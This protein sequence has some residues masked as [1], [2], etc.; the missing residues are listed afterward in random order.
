MKTIVR[1][2][3]FLAALVGVAATGLG[4]GSV[5]FFTSSSNSWVGQGESFTA[6][7][8]NGFTITAQRLPNNTV[9][10]SIVSPA[11]SWFLDFAAPDGALLA[12][13]QYF[14]AEQ[15]P[16]QPAGV[17]GMNFYSN[18]RSSSSIVGYFDVIAVEYGPG[19]TIN[20][21]DADFLQYDEGQSAR[22]NQGS[23]RFDGFAPVPE[24]GTAPLILAGVLTLLAM[25][26]RRCPR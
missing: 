9:S 6:S 13:N 1:I 24:P 2:S 7:S 21:F 20:R 16:N 25:N 14:G 12:T 3:L 15:T 5:F 19:N 4:Q 26:W 17:P 18:T 11:R 10:I 8:T 23:I 22:W